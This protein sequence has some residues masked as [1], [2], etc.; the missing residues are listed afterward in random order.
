VLSV[1]FWPSQLLFYVSCKVGG[2]SSLIVH[3]T[4]GGLHESA[5]AREYSELSLSSCRNYCYTLAEA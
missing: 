1:S 3:G 4:A 2:R 5:S